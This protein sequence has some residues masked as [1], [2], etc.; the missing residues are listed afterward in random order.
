MPPA[1]PQIVAPSA[2]KPIEAP[3]RTVATAPIKL[4]PP[5]PV[6]PSAG[7][8]SAT[9]GTNGKEPRGTQVAALPSGPAS[10]PEILD[11]G[12]TYRIP[13]GEDSSN[14]SAAG[15]K[16]LDTLAGRMKS[17]NSMRIQLLGYAGS[18]GESASKARRTSLFRALSVR[19]Y[20][21]KQ[22]IRSTRI[23]VRAL[24]NRSENGLQ[25]RVDAVVKQ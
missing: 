10:Q 11:N 4:P 2:P 24:G 18:Q 8:K 25:D 1:P 19:T 21:M 7:A 23:D 14:I 12:R 6:L 9:G 16:Q 22:G 20:L 13:F 3:A 17:N 5:E 15:Q